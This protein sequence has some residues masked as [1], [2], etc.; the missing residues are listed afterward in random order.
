M[1]DNTLPGTRAIIE[2][3]ALAGITETQEDAEKGWNAMS[4][5][6][7]EQTLIAYEMLCQ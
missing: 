5:D 4:E 3:Q 2:L 6:E 1:S 7:Q